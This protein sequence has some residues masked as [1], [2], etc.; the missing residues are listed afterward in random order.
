MRSLV[1]TLLH[2]STMATDEEV[3]AQLLPFS[4]PAWGVLWKSIEVWRMNPTPFTWKPRKSKSPMV[5]DNSW[6]EYDDAFETT[7][8]SLTEVGLML[9]NLKWQPLRGTYD[10]HRQNVST[11]SLADCAR[12]LTMAGLGDR[13]SE[14]F[15]ASTL[16]DGIFIAALDRSRVH[17]D[18]ANKTEGELDVLA[19]DES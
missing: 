1:T 5:S 15:M 12:W 17:V 14:G 6:V 18:A 19:E 16:R 11:F 7:F 13:F 10:D 2:T 9:P 4:D 8:R 3:L